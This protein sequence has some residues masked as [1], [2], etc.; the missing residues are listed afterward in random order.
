MSYLIMGR[1]VGLEKKKRRGREAVCAAD[2]LSRACSVDEGGV[3][4][5][6]DGDDDTVET[7]RRAKDLDDEHLE[8]QLTL[9]CVADCCATPRNADR[10]AAADVANACGETSA[11]HAETSV[12][13][14]RRVWIAL[15]GLDVE[16]QNDGHNDAVDGNSLA[17][18]NADQML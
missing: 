15:C 18:Q 17:E 9:L 8:E 16:L 14:R 6:D 11:E 5:R 7:E 10:D 13:H 4:N 1:N 2:T 12:I 3:S